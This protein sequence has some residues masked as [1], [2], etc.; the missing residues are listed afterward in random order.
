[1]VLKA[2]LLNIVKVRRAIATQQKGGVD[3]FELNT[4]V[5]AMNLLE[6]GLDD[7]AYESM[8]QV[9]GGENGGKLILKL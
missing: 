7:E 3:L 9:N 4:L 2:F 1:M 8:Y 6:I 5:H